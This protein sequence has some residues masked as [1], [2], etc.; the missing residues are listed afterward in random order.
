MEEDGKS[1][2]IRIKNWQN[3]YGVKRGNFK[4]YKKFTNRRSKKIRKKLNINFGRKFSNEKYDGNYIHP[5]GLDTFDQ[6]RIN[7]I[8]ESILLQ[9]E[10][11]YIT[12][13]ESKQQTSNLKTRIVKKKLRK[14]LK[15]IQQLMNN[16]GEKIP[17]VKMLELKVYEASIKSALYLEHKNFREAKEQSVFLLVILK[18]LMEISTAVERAQIE[19]IINSAQQ[20]LR[21]CKFQLRE[22]D[23]DEQK[24]M[25]LIMDRAD[26][27]NILNKFTDETDVTSRSAAKIK[28]FGSVIDVDDK[29][30][31]NIIN[32]EDL[33]KK[34][35]ASNSE[36]QTRE[37]IFWEIVNNY[38]E[39][40]K[41]C[42][43][44][45]IDAG[46]NAS[47]AKIWDSIDD[48][49]NFKKIAFL[50]KRNFKIFENHLKKQL[51]ADK[52][53][54]IRPQE[55]AK[56]LENLLSNIRKLLDLYS[57]YG[58]KNY[59]LTFLEDYYRLQKCYYISMLYYNNKL[60]LYSL[61]LNIQEQKNMASLAD[62][63]K[64]NCTTIL[65]EAKE[66]DDEF[67]MDNDN[68]LQLLVS[69]N[70]EN[71]DRIDAEFKI[72]TKQAKV[73]LY[74]EQQS[75]MNELTESI[76]T[77]NL[78]KKFDK[79]SNMNCL[80]DLVLEN[81]AS[82]IEEYMDFIKIPPY[83]SLVTAKPIFLDLANDLINYPAI[84]Y[85]LM[86]KKE[87]EPEKK[88]GFFGRFWNK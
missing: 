68:S 47:L 21:Y 23:S 48:Y 45:K 87:S 15:L 5:V 35:Y 51:Q 7:A 44:Y 36:A 58:L 13:Q 46:N 26:I 20:T 78:K 3:L 88:K 62:T 82:N 43:Q 60:Y 53:E 4:A 38:E 10:K 73:A 57:K 61:S 83:G 72:L 49:F 55:N 25:L 50:M 18:Q 9:V 80:L 54:E 41:I 2:L 67:T 70:I 79:S 17:K 29:K 14:A 11:N 69:K 6:N 39:G 66:F 63:I 24:D 42:H 40:I 86:E 74:D 76:G 12:Y 81:R 85:S 52:R 32:K 31:L 84:D 59:L 27:S 19:E 8:V 37:D 56:L 77:M 75:K 71:L 33:L 64:G 1:L 28:A 30:L 16:F 34:S 65:N 22:F